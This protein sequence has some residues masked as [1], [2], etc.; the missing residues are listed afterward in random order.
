MRDVTPLRMK[1]EQS[2][3]CTTQDPTLFSCMRRSPDKLRAFALAS[4]L[5]SALA[6]KCSIIYAN[7]NNV[8]GHKRCLFMVTSLMV[9]GSVGN[10]RRCGRCGDADLQD[11]PARLPRRIT[12]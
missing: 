10:I 3:D 2:S 6:S 1:P 7:A 12:A 8:I 4:A 11:R 5:P 9:C